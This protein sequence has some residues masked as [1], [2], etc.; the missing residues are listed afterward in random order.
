MIP[1]AAP[2]VDIFPILKYIPEIF[3]KWKSNARRLRATVVADAQRFVTDGKKQR[4]QVLHKP[5]SVRFEGLIAKL[6][7]ERDAATTQ[8]LGRAFTDLELGY[9]GQALVGAAV[10]TTLDAF[11]SLM[12]CLAAFPAVLRKVHDEVDRV[13]GDKPPA[14]EQIN[15]LPY[16][17]ACVSEAGVLP[18]LS[19]FVCRNSH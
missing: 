17:K 18:S 12:C 10:D 11:T 2:P 16:L 6:L 4:A 5:A 15:D 3:A 14:G 1:G 7:G 19:C 13:S 9:I 8:N